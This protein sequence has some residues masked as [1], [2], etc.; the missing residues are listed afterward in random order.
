MHVCMQWYNSYNIKNSPIYYL[1]DYFNNHFICL[2][3]KWYP[4]SQ[5]PLHQLPHPMPL[6]HFPLPLWGCS[7]THSPTPA[8]PLSTPHMGHQASSPP[9]DAPCEGW[10]QIRHPLLHME[11][12]LSPCILSGWWFSPWELWVVWLVTIVLLMELQSPSDPSVLP[13]ALHW[14]PQAQSDGWLWVSASVRCW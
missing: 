3:F 7:S 10:L 14:G 4:P 8:S 1:G 5:L 6:P 11:S 12:W 2:H 13:L 9:T